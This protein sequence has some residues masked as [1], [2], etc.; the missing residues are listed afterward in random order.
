[1]PTRWIAVA[2]L[3]SGLLAQGVLG[4]D[5]EDGI[6]NWPTPLLW[7]S[8][9]KL[10]VDSGP[11]GSPRPLHEA[12]AVTPLP[13]I[14]VPPCRVVDTRGNGFTGQYGPPS[15]AAGSPRSFTLIGRCGIAA[16]AQAV[17]LNITVT[18]TQGPG[19]IKIFPQGGASPTVSTLN[20]SA[21]QTLAN[22]AVVTLGAGGGVTIAAGVSGT[23]LIVDTNGYYDGSGLI[24]QVSP[25]TGLAGGGAAG[26][27]MLGIAAG[28]VTS[29]E[30]ASNAV[31]SS[32]ISANAVTAGAIASG[33]VVKGVNGLF[34]NITLSPGSNVTIT[35][36]GSTLTI[37]SS[38]GSGPPSGT[39]GG[40]LSGTY[41]NPAVV[42]SSANTPNAIVSRDGSGS[43]AAG[44]ISGNL[45][46]SVTGAASANVLKAGDTMTGTLILTTG[47]IDLANSTA[48]SGNISK[49][50]TSFIH[51]FGGA[52]H[53]NT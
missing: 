44:T 16:T 20:F 39:A 3:G 28:G 25:G 38:A 35:P 18:N 52:A 17:S 14:A 47:N 23:D 10:G 7:K 53:F 41:P 31:T 19:F 1:M 4:Q 5:F 30:L 12:T 24:T 32:K 40:G 37:A 46:G 2:I 48:S 6:A 27:V 42:S 15:L 33:Q 21:G 26:D 45:A 8:Q 50:G 29:N 49:N 13:L 9:A 36:S 51:N 22:A 11:G 43:F 34:D